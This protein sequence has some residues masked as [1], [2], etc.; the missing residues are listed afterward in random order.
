MTTSPEALKR[1]I[2][3]HQSS[4]TTLK[5]SLAQAKFEIFES[6]MSAT[7]S[8][9]Q[10]AIENMTRLAQGLTGMRASCTLQHRLIRAREDGWFDEMEG[11]GNEKG[12]P[13]SEEEEAERAKLRGE[14]L[15]LERFKERVGPSMKALTVRQSSALLN[16]AQKLI[17]PTFA[18]DFDSRSR[19]P[20]HILRPHSSW[21]GDPPRNSSS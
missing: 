20:P 4:F 9:Y 5:S 15:V 16:R 8:A 2:D 3:A 11:N 6:R 17:R 7:T 18:A 1:A 13:R 12:L 14:M 19:P 10:D 21:I